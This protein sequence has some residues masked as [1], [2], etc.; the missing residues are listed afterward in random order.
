M[1]DNNIEIKNKQFKLSEVI[2]LICIT[3][4]I[5][6][7]I[8]LSLFNI[9]GDKTTKTKNSEE[10]T[11]L[12]DNYNYI[13]DNYYGEIDKDKL[14]S[15]AIEGMLKSID[16]PYTTYIDE[17]NSNIFTT[18]L[19]GQFEGIGVEI[20]NDANNNI[21]VYSVIENS[22]AERAGIKSMDIIKR[23][24]DKSLENVSTQE[25]VTMVKNNNSPTF[26]L[27]ILRGNEEIEVTVTREMVTIK[28]VESEIFE[29]NNKKIGYIYMSV[30]ANNT[31]KQFKEE[32][33][34]LENS[35]INSLIIDVRS[36]TGGHLTSVENILSLFLDSSH[37][38][39]Q[40]ED[41][42]GTIKYYSKGNETKTYPIIVLTN[43]DSASASEILAGAL[44]EEYNA[45]IVGKNTFGKGTVQE[46]KT[47][48]DGEQYKFTTKKW[49]TPQ[50]EW[51]NE[52]GISVDVEVEF[53]K[54][55]YENPV[56]E[57]DQQLQMAIDV[58][59][60]K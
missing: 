30:F 28:S 4:I 53:N 23:L 38:L 7:I 51:I 60:K 33:L 19:E 16:D 50:G 22:P 48:P 59:S 5:G 44:K 10:I 36:N 24:G 14:V 27:T 45:T 13:V 18:T 34:N 37:V 3:A 43:E 1:N 20:V 12:I 46:L 58:A 57:N 32:L 52:K 15:S 8:G 55:Y 25:F 21:V 49:L 56:Y 54:N 47:L 35:Q 17:N 40:T 26:S 2:I 9:L 29:H 42:E 11:M 31:Y 6:F 39:Y 41:K